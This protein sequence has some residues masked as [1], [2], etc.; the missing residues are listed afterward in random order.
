[1][2]AGLSVAP[3]ELIREQRSSS[4]VWLTGQMPAPVA[5]LY[6]TDGADWPT[7]GGEGGGESD[8]PP[9]QLIVARKPGLAFDAAGAVEP[10]VGRSGLDERGGEA[11]VCSPVE[12]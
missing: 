11:G 8:E 7:P 10:R 3:P 9:A 12:L 4:C 1:M 2:C 5:D 6:E